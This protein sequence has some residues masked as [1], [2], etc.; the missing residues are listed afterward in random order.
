[1]ASV[2]PKWGVTQHFPPALAYAIEMLHTLAR[3]M[4][5]VMKGTILEGGE[6][7]RVRF[8]NRVL[9]TENGLFGSDR[10]NEVIQC[11]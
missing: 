10:L 11:Y 1:M 9:G 6:K 8:W 7:A 2:V 5:S 3:R 4:R